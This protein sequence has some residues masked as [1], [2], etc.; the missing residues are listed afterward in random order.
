MYKR[1]TINRRTDREAQE[2]LPGVN[3]AE[4]VANSPLRSKSPIQESKHRN[5]QNPELNKRA[6]VTSTRITRQLL[7]DSPSVNP[8]P[9]LAILHAES[10]IYSNAQPTLDPES[11]ER[12]CQVWAEV[13]RAILA[14]RSK[15][16]E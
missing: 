11:V 3:K 15:V 2:S 14:R 5:E 1:L 10:D 13:G 6:P 9:A 12:F 7:Q 4:V 8:T 16:T